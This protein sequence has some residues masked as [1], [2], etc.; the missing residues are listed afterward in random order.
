MERKE[1]GRAEDGAEE[2]CLQC[3]PYFS[4]PS[5]HKAYVTLMIGRK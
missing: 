4:M 3:I 1:G 2:H 5:P